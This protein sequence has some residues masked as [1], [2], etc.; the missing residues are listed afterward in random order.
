MRHPHARQRNTGGQD[1]NGYERVVAALELR[2]PDQIPLMELYIHP[3]VIEGLFPGCDLLELLERMDLDGVC[4]MRGGRQ[5]D[6]GSRPEVYVDAWGTRFGRTAEAYHPMEGPIKSMADLESYIPPDPNDRSLLAPVRKAVERFKG[7]RFIA[8]HNAPDFM[9]AAFLRGLPEFLMDLKENPRFAHR[10]LTIVNDYAC[11]LSRRAI[12]AGADA[13]VLAGDWAFN[14]GPFMSPAD[15]QEFVLPYFKRCIDVCHEAGGYAI[16]HSDGNLWPIIDMIVDSGVD[17]L[18]PIQP[19]AGM[20]IGEVKARY[21]DRICLA[22]NINCGYTLSEAPVER[23]ARE[24]KEAIRKAGPGGGYIMTSSNSLHSSVKA[25]N[26][27]A[28]VEATRMYG[29][30][31]LDMAALS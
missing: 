12:E 18:N 30:Y 8:F 16:K 9:P 1:V 13:V 11:T 5:P 26:Y 7:K 29:K 15:F 17:A 6:A 21:G 23:V 10:L 19:D 3:K 4:L 14:T 20:D 27:K 24:V 28:M 31:P 22:G 25:E 2:E